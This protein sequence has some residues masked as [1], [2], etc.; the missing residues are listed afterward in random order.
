MKR[1]FCIN[2]KGEAR[3]IRVLSHHQFLA[4]LPVKLCTQ[5]DGEIHQDLAR[6]PQD[7]PCPYCGAATFAF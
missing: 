5:C 7:E 2:R 1:V 3:A 6:A 4:W